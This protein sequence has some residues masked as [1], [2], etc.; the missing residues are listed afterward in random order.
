MAQRLLDVWLLDGNTVYREVPFTVVADWLQQGRLLPEDRV[1]LANG[2]KWL[3]LIDV[4][5]FQPYLPGTEPLAAEDAAEA[6]A[7]V[8]MELGWPKRRDEEDDDVDMIPLIDISLVLLIFFMMTA[9]V[10]SGIIS[11]IQTPPAEHQLADIAKDMYWVGVEKGLDDELRFSFGDDTGTLLPPKTEIQ[12]LERAVKTQLDNR[13][14]PVRMRIRADLNLPIEVVQGLT[15]ELQGW[16][17]TMNAS[18]PAGKGPLALIIYAEVS[19]PK[20]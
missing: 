8:E 3:P 18:R 1:R 13:E 16:E 14:G 15:L 5:A 11:P 20:Q 19:E 9:S 2:K 7:P 10:A 17:K 4:S 6:L 12:D